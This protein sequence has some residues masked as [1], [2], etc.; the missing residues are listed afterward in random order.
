MKNCSLSVFVFC[1]IFLVAANAHAMS[2]TAQPFGSGVIAPPPS[3]SAEVDKI[4]RQQEEEFLAG[5]KAKSKTNAVPSWNDDVWVWSRPASESSLKIQSVT[6]TATD[7]NEGAFEVGVIGETSSYTLVVFGG[8]ADR[9]VDSQ[10]YARATIVSGATAEIQLPRTTDSGIELWYT[11]MVWYEGIADD[12]SDLYDNYWYSIPL[13][14]LPPPAPVLPTAVP[15][16]T[17]TATTIPTATP[18]VTS[19]PTATATEVPPTATPTMTSTP[20]PTATATPIEWGARNVEFSQS[21]QVVSA[22]WSAAG[23]NI[24]DYFIAKLRMRDP[25]R[26]W[27]ILSGELVRYVDTSDPAQYTPGRM[28]GVQWPAREISDFFGEDGGAVILTIESWFD[29]ADSP[30]AVADGYS[31]DFHCTPRSL[32]SL[33]FSEA[34]IVI[35]NNQPGVTVGGN[36][37]IWFTPKAGYSDLKVQAQIWIGREN[38]YPEEMPSQRLLETREF[39]SR[40]W[41]FTLK[42]DAVI[43]GQCI[44]WHY[45]LLVHYDGIE[46][47][48]PLDSLVDNHWYSVPVGILDS[49]DSAIPVIPLPSAPRNVDLSRAAAGMTVDS[50]AT[51]QILADDE[52]NPVLWVTVSNP[53]DQATFYFPQVTAFSEAMWTQASIRILAGSGYVSFGLLEGAPEGE[54]LSGNMGMSFLAQGTAEWKTFGTG[55][56]TYTNSTVPFLQI[57]G[58]SATTFIVEITGWQLGR[59]ELFFVAK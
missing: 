17:P 6:L 3:S 50:T 41:P 21:G 51:V 56:I 20:A 15:T 43:G 13:G 46:D 31:L 8:R 2:A 35:T 4:I 37:K 16:A 18:T 32:D 48:L 39:S 26:D 58:S 5:S 30:A 36:A 23:N 24:P 45:T 11:I 1:A 29:G 57:T 54:N 10:Q 52:G 53:G 55:T 22:T 38:D 14:I 28:T 34:G 33:R 19:T 49:P 59:P 42:P 25:D 27:I 40:G 12:T 44:Q 47:E 9:G 7:W